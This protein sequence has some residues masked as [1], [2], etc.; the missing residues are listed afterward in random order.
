MM[1]A[2]PLWFVPFGGGILL[3]AV[4]VGL[5]LSRPSPASSASVTPSPYPKRIVS[6]NPCMDAVLVQLADHSRIAAISHY[7]HDPE[8]TSTPLAIARRFAVTSGTAEEVLAMRPDLVIAGPHVAL[9]TILAL[10]RLKIP[11]LQWP[12]PETLD[13]NRSQIT[14]LAAALDA[15]ERGEAL[16][17][18]IDAAVASAKPR[19]SNPVPALIWQA[20]G[21]VPG[22]NTLADELLQATGFHN[23]SPDYGMAT[24]D[25][26]PLE[27]LV[28]HPPKVLLSNAGA[29]NER[30]R[31]LSH[32]AIASLAHR[33]KVRPFPFRLLQCA[34]PNVIEAVG[35]LSRIRRTIGQPS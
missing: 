28:A 9:P 2:A 6:L 29:A 10:R 20:N 1:R 24:W 26:L 14:E 12:V 21:L 17:A 11:L 5:G 30:D 13:Q 18:A 15:P 33:I 32:P 3:F 25:I 19:D 31:M 7:S 16:N 4:L 8:A 22:K 34:G 23:L 35:I 27:Q